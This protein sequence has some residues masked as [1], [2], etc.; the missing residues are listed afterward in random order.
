[1]SQQ[2]NPNP[3]PELDALIKQFV[4]AIRDN[5][6][7]DNNTLDRATPRW[8][9]RK[10]RKGKN[11]WFS[12]CMYCRKGDYC[13]GPYLY[14]YWKE[15]GKLRKKYM[16]KDPENI[17]SKKIEQCYSHFERLGN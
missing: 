7:P 2:P 5:S 14:L 9:Y 4:E 8:E 1:M 12:D 16:G 17:L 11:G 15:K 6:L 13:Q 3:S 10:C